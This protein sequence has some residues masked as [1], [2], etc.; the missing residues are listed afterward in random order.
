MSS[1]KNSTVSWDEAVHT[2]TTPRRPLSLSPIVVS[3]ND[4]SSD[5][6]DAKRPGKKRPTLRRRIVVNPADSSDDDE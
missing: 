6:T 5:E 1:A 3:N 4:A 2:P